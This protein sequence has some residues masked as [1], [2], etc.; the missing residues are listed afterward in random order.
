V[1]AGERTAVAYWATREAEPEAALVA[2][3]V[4]VKAQAASEPVAVA[5]RGEGEAA[6]ATTRR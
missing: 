3:G 4:G 6:A 1:V 2:P 5:V